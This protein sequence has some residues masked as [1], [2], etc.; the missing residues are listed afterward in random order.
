[1]AYMRILKLEHFIKNVFEALPSI[2]FLHIDIK[3]RKRIC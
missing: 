3:A 1:M 2:Y